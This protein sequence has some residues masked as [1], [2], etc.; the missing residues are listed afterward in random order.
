MDVLA[1]VPQRVLLKYE[2]EMN[3]VPKNVMIK[4]W[5]PQRAILCKILSVLIILD[6]IGI[7]VETR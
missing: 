4:K 7:T 5:L 3:D 2:G 1:R 6:F